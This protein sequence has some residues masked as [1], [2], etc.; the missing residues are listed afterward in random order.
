MSKDIK[1]M[2]AKQLNVDVAKVA[3][4][5][6]IVEDLGADSLD[7]VEL[8]M[9]LEDEMGISISDEEALNLKTVGDIQKLIDE[10]KEDK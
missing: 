7:V 5:S 1:S 4:D 2:L 9:S 8:L 10:R 6:R 3:D